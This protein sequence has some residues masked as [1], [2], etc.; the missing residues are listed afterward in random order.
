MSGIN[1]YSGAVGLGGALT[2]PTVLSRRKGSIDKSYPIKLDGRDYPDVEAAYH[3]LKTGDVVADDRMMAVAIAIKFRT[4]PDLRDEV[5]S[6]GGVSFLELCTHWTT[7][8]D[9]EFKL[10]TKSGLMW[11]GA[12]MDSRFIRN[13][14]EGF[15]LSFSEDSL[16][17]T[18]GS[19]F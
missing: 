7:R 12:G 2:N 16:V 3:C 9:A 15:K 19:L 17:L 10:L 6:R 18:Q 14:I 5:V 1:I 13:L 8:T 11:E 4:Y